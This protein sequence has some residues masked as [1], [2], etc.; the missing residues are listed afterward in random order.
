[1]YLSKIKGLPRLK[2]FVTWQISCFDSF[3]FAP[4]PVIYWCVGAAVN[5]ASLRSGDIATVARGTIPG[6]GVLTPI[7]GCPVANFQLWIKI[8]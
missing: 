8:S 2:R 6:V 5:Y 1:M 4:L 3:G 7:K